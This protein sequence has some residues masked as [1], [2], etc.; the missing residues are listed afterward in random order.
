LLHLEFPDDE[1]CLPPTIQQPGRWKDYNSV[2][3]RT[4]LPN[5]F[6]LLNFLNF[7]IYQNRSQPYKF[8]RL[9]S[10]RKTSDFYT[11]I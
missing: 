9:G 1:F 4:D 6:Y 10:L 7:K 2:K 11:M 8:V 5:T 3:K